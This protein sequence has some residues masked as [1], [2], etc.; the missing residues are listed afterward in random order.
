LS[1]IPSNSSKHEIF[2]EFDSSL[3]S[4]DQDHSWKVSE[5]VSGSDEEAIECELLCVHGDFEEMGG[6]G[7]L[8]DFENSTAAFFGTVS[9]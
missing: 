1:L 8:V 6:F 4:L 2:I 5:L 3:A 7:Y 9:F